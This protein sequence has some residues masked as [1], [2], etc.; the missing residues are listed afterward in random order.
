[1]SRDKNITIHPR[2][3]IDKSTTLCAERFIFMLIQPFYLFIYL[4]ISYSTG[5]SLYHRR[6]SPQTLQETVGETLCHYYYY[7]LV[8]SIERN[9]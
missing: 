5:Y 2:F 9:V 1:M 4:F 6:D 7:I 3:K 8:V